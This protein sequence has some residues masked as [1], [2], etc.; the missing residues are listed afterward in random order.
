MLTNKTEIIQD[1]VSNTNE[2]AVL[3]PAIS[4]HVF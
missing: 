2:P 1:N 4:R 3:L